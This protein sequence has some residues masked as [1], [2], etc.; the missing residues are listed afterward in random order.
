MVV[1]HNYVNGQPQCGR[2]RHRDLASKGTCSRCRQ[3]RRLTR[4]TGLAGLCEPCAGI[5]SEHICS[6]CGAEDRLYKD[7]LCARCNVRDA[8]EP[9]IEQ[10][11]PD[12]AEKL[13]SYL[14]ALIE[15]QQPWSTMHWIRRSA[16]Y[17]V[18]IDILAGRRPLEHDALDAADGGQAIE[19]LRSALVTHGALP[20]RDDELFRFTRWL[21]EQTVKVS[22]TTDHQHLKTW[23]HWHLLNDLNYRRRRGKLT[24]RSVQYARMQVRQTIAF[25][26]WLHGQ[27]LQLAECEQ[28]HIDEWFALGNT[29]S[30]RVTSFLRW[31]VKN[32]LIPKI[33]IPRVDRPLSYRSLQ[34]TERRALI[35]RL[36]N[37]SSIDLRDRVAGLLVLIYGQ[38]IARIARLQLEDVKTSEQEVL[39][40]LGKEPIAIVEPLASLLADLAREPRSRAVTAATRTPWLFP[41]K[42]VGLHLNYER[43]RNRLRLL[44]IPSR[45]S[46]ASALLP[47]AREVPAPILAETLGLSEEKAASWARAAASDYARYAASRA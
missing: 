32:R 16:A 8:L 19:H 7:R 42:V 29:T 34:D 21:D 17:D 38:P 24:G 33:T 36:I 27:D 23:V 30:M 25:I 3:H 43:L 31:A 2:C 13:G 9:H 44:G 12:L 39:L 10:A 37:D 18:L 28:G 46:R 40:R 1:I 6:R 4:L 15:T 26:E 20:P 5:E 22:G 47:L 45:T 35:D 14:D 41:G 11:T